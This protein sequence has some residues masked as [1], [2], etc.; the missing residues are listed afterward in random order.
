[1]FTNFIVWIKAPFL[2]DSKGKEVI[3]EQD[4]SSFKNSSGILLLSESYLN[5]E[6]PQIHWYYC[7]IANNQRLV[8][9]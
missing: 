4:K 8:W 7:M 1:M 6:K 2:D 3:Q 9:P 5:M